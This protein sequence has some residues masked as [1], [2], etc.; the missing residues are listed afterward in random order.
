MRRGCTVT[1]VLVAMA[2]LVMIAALL[3]PV[4]IKLRESATRASCQNNLRQHGLA[5]DNYHAVNGKFP[6]GTMPNADLAPDQ[7]LS[8]HI[9]VVPFVEATNI[10]K[11]LAKGE[12]WDSPANVAVVANYTARL[13]QCP[14]WNQGLKGPLA[15]SGHLAYTNYVGVAGVGADAATR[16]A[17]GPGIGIIG[18]DR[19]LKKTDVKDGLENTLL[20]IEAAHD[21]G[22]WIRGGPSTVR[23]IEGEGPF[24]S[25]HFYRS[26]LLQKRPEGFNVLLADGS[27]RFTKAD[28]APVVLAA[29]ATVAGGEEAPKDW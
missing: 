20:L 22:P 15:H 5:I 24:G 1:E 25:A 27:V 2:V 13:Y 26:W 3:F 9:A 17:E 14:H 11:Q 6:P 19:A 10:Y 21:V 29:L 8:F 18:Y 12:P 7:R 16:P 28:I 4:V 23:A